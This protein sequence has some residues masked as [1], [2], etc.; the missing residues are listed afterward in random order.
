MQL[1]LIEKLNYKIYMYINILHTIPIKRTIDIV[2]NNLQNLNPQI[3]NIKHYT[4]F[5]AIW[6]IHL[7]ITI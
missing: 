6:V 2:L 7:H 3:I 5:K 1:M 4:R